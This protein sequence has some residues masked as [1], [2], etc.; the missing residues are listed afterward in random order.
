VVKHRRRLC[1]VLTAAGLVLSARGA[2]AHPEISP[3]LVNRYLALVVIDSRVEVFASYLFGPLPG[4][5]RRRSMDG[6][7]D[8]LIS[9]IEMTEEARRWAARAGEL[10]TLAI[11]GQDTVARATATVELGTDRSTGAAAVVIELRAQ[12]ALVPGPH[13]LRIEPGRDPDRLGE[14]EL[15]IDPGP[16]W[17]LAASHL[18]RAAPPAEGHVAL[19]RFKFDGPRVSLLEDR[20]A[21]FLVRTTP[22]EPAPGHRGV[23]GW[24]LG[25]AFGAALVGSLA[26]VLR[27]RRPPRAGA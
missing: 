16:G 20:S 8:G 7:Q 23:P 2:G 15:G 17:V 4:A 21:T 5:E 22:V 1:L 10:Y 11:D 26:V 12:V 27:R 13:A 9:E 24:L 19:A 3:Q 14:T 25:G 6:D 18:G